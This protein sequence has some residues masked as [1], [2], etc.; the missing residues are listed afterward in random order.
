V[1]KQ[2]VVITRGAV[3]MAFFVVLLTV[4]DF[5]V[6]VFFEE[7]FGCD[8]LGAI[9]SLVLC[10][11]ARRL[12]SALPLIAFEHLACLALDAPIKHR[13]TVGRT[14]AD[15]FC[16]AHVTFRRVYAI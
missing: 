8:T 1:T 7:R 5:I 14:L 6:A 12:W 11:A 9:A 15:I 4:I 13:V 3:S 10:D 2:L 16:V